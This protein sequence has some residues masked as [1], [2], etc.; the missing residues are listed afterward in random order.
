MSW[1]P[2][3]YQLEA[4]TKLYDAWDKHLRCLLV[5]AT[6]TGKT[7]IFSRVAERKVADNKRVLIC[8]HRD[9]LMRQAVAELSEQTGIHAAIEKSSLTAEHT[10]FPVTVGSIQSMSQ[11]KRLARIGHAEYDTVII[12]EAH[13]SVSKTYRRV[14]EHFPLARV[15]GVTATDDRSDKVNLG[16][17]YDDI[18]FEYSYA[19]AV[20]DGWLCKPVAKQIPL[21]I[22]ISKVKITGGDF[23][24]NGLGEVLDDYLPQ[25][26][27][28]VPHDRKTMCFL[29]L[30][31]T[32]RKF[33]EICLSEGLNAFYAGGDDRSELSAWESSGKGSIMC[34]A[35]LLGEGYNHPQIDA[36]MVLRC[37][38]S[39]GA[40]VQ[41][42][43]RGTRKYPGKDHL[44]ILDFLWLTDR[45]DLCRPASLIAETDAIE[46]CMNRKVKPGVEVDLFDC[47]AEARSDVQHA[48][49][50]RL[51]QE[52][53]LNKRK[54]SKLIDPLSYALS[55][56]SLAIEDYKPVLSWQKEPITK[57]QIEWLER[58]GLSVEG[59]K[60][61]GHA[62]VVLAEAFNRKQSGMA[63]PKQISKLKA[64]KIDASNY[65]FIKANALL[66]K[67]FSS[68]KKR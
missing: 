11:P 40:Y 15:L 10:L 57:M 19:Q 22:D 14:I 55:V 1:A 67:L 5:M 38:R 50:A 62:S 30:R 33:K 20:K 17:V 41:M 4:L 66:N 63:S 46:D 68:R 51:A 58:L 26:A 47:L 13:H 28:H 37:T 18:P 16:R 32:A 31:A 3:P 43:G 59:I 61:K 49:E 24:E 36:V 64:W 54:A 6:G 42:V 52:L 9:E 56:H 25:I 29:P 7:Y 53:A 12:D 8:V 34:N 27:K 35:M 21:D 39:R 2:R 23:S 60:D 48:L 65:T 45:H 44:L